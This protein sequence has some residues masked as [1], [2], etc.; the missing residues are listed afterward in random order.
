VVTEGDSEY[1][2]LPNLFEQLRNDVGDLEFIKITKLPVQP[3]GPPEKIKRE[4]S[5]LAAIFKAKNVDL[6]VLLLD[7]E[8][9]PE[10]AGVVALRIQETVAAAF[11]SNLSVVLKD[12]DFENWVIAD[13]EAL[14]GL[15]GRFDI[16]PGFRRSVSPNK[17][18]RVSALA[19]LKKAS[20]TGD[21]DKIQDADRVLSRASIDRIGANSRSFRHF[22]HVL[23]HPSHERST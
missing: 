3:D 4:C 14:A 23:G 19:M 12:R 2:A 5:K 17:A 21:Y 18:D 11:V 6:V 1:K 22:L 13:V 9:Q 15:P 20:K 8:Q 16:T 10:S 7:R